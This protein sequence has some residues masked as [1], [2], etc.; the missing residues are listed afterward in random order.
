MRLAH[1]REI[2]DG[3]ARDVRALV[4]AQTLRSTRGIAANVVRF[5]GSGPLGGTTES[6]TSASTCSGCSSA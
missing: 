6:S 3:F 5:S 4:L 1:A 2:R